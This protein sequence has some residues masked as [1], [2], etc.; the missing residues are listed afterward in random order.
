[1]EVRIESSSTLRIW[2]A[3]AWESAIR[4]ASEGVGLV[5]VEEGG[6]R[7]TMSGGLLGVL[8]VLTVVVV[9]VEV[10]VEGLRGEDL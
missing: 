8:G 1:M 9:E 3:C 4:R 10:G 6:A 5:P 7:E 2:R